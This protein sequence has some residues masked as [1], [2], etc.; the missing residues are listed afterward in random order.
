MKKFDSDSVISEY[1]D[2]YIRK[3]RITG[4]ISLRGCGRFIDINHNEDERIQYVL[5]HYSTYPQFTD[6]RAYFDYMATVDENLFAIKSIQ[7]SP[8]QSEELLNNWVAEIDWNTIKKELQ[9]LAK[10]SRN[11]EHQILKFIPAPVRLEFLSALA[12]KS[13]LPSIRVIPNYVCD[14]T[15]LPTSTA[16]GGIGDIE[17]LEKNNGIL[18]EVTMAE[19]RQQTMMEIWP[20]ERH[21]TQFKERYTPESQCLFIAPSIFGDSLRQIAFVKQDKG[22]I[23]RPYPIEDFIQYLETTHTLYIA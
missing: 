20:I 13:K 4:L 9:I 7:T 15:G 5:E 1:P 10:R 8:T 6:G 17:C 22:H 3:M 11:C 14:D 2:E 12:I 23:I 18:I 16:G 19:G 21:L